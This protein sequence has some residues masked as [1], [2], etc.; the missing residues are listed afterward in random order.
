[1]RTY[2]YSRAVELINAEK[3]L[4]TAE[5]GMYEDWFWTAETVWENGNYTKE[6]KTAPRIAGISGSCWATPSIK[7]TYED[8]TELMLPCFTGESTQE[9]PIG[10]ELG[11]LS[12]P[13]QDTLPPLVEDK[14]SPD[15]SK[16]NGTPSECKETPYE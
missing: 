6:L 13:A 9:Q 11:V 10:F 7:L 4:A 5:M 14:P 15:E 12:S 2:N 8:G 1:M 3:N 16:C